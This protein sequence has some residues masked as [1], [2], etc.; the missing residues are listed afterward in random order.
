MMNRRG[1]LVALTLA[2]FLVPAASLAAQETQVVFERTGY[3]LTAIGARVSVTAR[4]LDARRRPVPNAPIAWRVQD[5]DVASVTN[6]GEVVSRRVGRTRVWAVSGRDSASALILVDQW[7]ASF[8]FNPPVLRFAAVGEGKPLQVQARDA[9]GNAIPGIRPAVACRVLDE[10]VA[11]MEGNGQVQARGSGVTWVRCADRG[12]ADSVR[13]EVRQRPVRAAIENKGAVAQRT[14]GDT[15]QIRMSATDAE[16][17]PVADARPTWASLEPGVVNIDPLTGRARAVSAGAAKIVAQI[18]DLTDTVSVT[19]V[20]GAGMLPPPV[21]VAAET[22]AATEAAPRATLRIFAT[23]PSVGDTA[24]V[25]LNARDATGA[26]VA[27]DAIQFRS[28]DTTIVKSLGAG[29][30]VGLKVGE[31]FLVATYANMTDS[32]LIAVSARGTRGVTLA[33]ASNFV[34]PSYDTTAADARNRAQIDSVR[35]A[36]LAASAIQVATGRYLS[37]AFFGSQA[38]HASHVSD[39]LSESRTGL[40]YGGRLS[41]AWFRRL[42]LQVSMLTGTLVGD[43]AERIEDMTVTEVEGALT[44]APVPWFGL[45]GAVTQRAEVTPIAANRWQFVSAGVHSRYS[46]VGGR[47]T[48][49]ASL[50]LLPVARLSTDEVTT[51]SADPTSMSGEA[52]IEIHT[53]VL[54]AGVSYYTERFT[55]PV[56]N[57]FQRRDQF[58]ML[59]LRLGLQAGR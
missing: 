36:I 15:F 38:S 40:M 17:R 58:S 18:G 19:V 23:Y 46:F 21:P 35:R 3:R 50:S 2:A 31:A 45:R 20:A 47:V 16:G 30:L 44:F 6:R 1:L 57:D 28:S 24:R 48:T 13:V 37:V 41:A 10:Q 52:G 4:V 7:A 34:R 5:P 22:A 54:T 55:F 9:S 29:R 59:R 11:A 49:F 33:G 14:A 12:V 42:P 26:A 53:G 43:Q 8:A 51:K 27:A 25:E 32:T 56:E 39:S